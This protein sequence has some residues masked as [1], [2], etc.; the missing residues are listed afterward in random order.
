MT[1]RLDRHG[2]GKP[3]GLLDTLINE[4]DVSK[5]AEHFAAILREIGADVHSEGMREP[6]RCV[7][8]PDR[9]ADPTTERGRGPADPPVYDTR[10]SILAPFE[11][12][13]RVEFDR[14]TNVE[15]RGY[16]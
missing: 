14:V 4:P 15:Y 8:A 11:V 13:R 1:S 10:D 2:P 5:P 3:D 12:A 7:R 9:G 16:V 6:A